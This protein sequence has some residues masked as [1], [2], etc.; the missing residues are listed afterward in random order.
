MATSLNVQGGLQT[1]PILMNA[2]ALG[3]LASETALVINTTFGSGI[4][5]S[6]LIKQVLMNLRIDNQAAA[7][8]VIIGLCNGSATVAEIASA[9][10]TLITDPDD[11]SSPAVAA[12]RQNIFWETLRMLAGATAP[13]QVINEK[14]SLGG[15]KGIPVKEATGLAIF[16]FN[17]GNNALTT[18]ST[19]QGIVTLRGIWLGD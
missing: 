3:T 19:V 5:Q 17:P 4:T 2:D 6:F 16:A 13:A 18:G 7:D 10:T 15:G 9:L 1:S 14:I 12:A 11:A 8:G